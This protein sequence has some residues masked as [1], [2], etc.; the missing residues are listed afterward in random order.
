MVVTLDW[1]IKSIRIFL[2]AAAA[3][4]FVV[5]F[6]IMPANART[7]DSGDLD[8]NPAHVPYRTTIVNSLC[9]YRNKPEKTSYMMADLEGDGNLELLAGYNGRL[10]GWDCEDGYIKPRFQINLEPG[11][12]FHHHSGT[13][14]G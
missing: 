5:L 6:N 3:V 1:I 11:W 8:L 9:Y 10:L 2:S 13:R 14:L 12:G 4:V 7:W